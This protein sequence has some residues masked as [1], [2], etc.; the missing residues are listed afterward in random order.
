MTASAKPAATLCLLCDDADGVRV[1]MARRPDD[2]RFMASAWVFPGGTLDPEDRE[3]ASSIAPEI[4]DLPW[5][6]CALRELGEEVGIWLTRT[7]AAR[8][9]VDVA[10]LATDDLAP[11]ARWV[12]PEVLPI[13]YDARF[14]VAAVDEPVEPRIDEELVDARWV[15]PGDALAAWERGDWE[16][17]LPTRTTLAELASFPDVASVLAAAEDASLVPIVPRLVPDGDGLRLLRPGEPGYDEAA[18][19]AED[20]AF[21]A[22]VLAAIDPGRPIPPSRP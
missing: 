9:P 20:P 6:L 13:R 19:Y 8:E 4:P 1:L 12:T 10:E 7:G 11:W 3:A 5:R 21:R 18:G 14:Y 22:R 2:S 17:A 15:R 16:L